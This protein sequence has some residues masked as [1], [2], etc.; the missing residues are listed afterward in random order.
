MIILKKTIM[1]RKGKLRGSK[2]Y[3]DDD[4]TKE[5]RDKEKGLKPLM[6]A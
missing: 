4:L 6:M 2:I 5:T 3:I 1:A